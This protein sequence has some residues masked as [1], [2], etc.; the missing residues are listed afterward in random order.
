M[1]SD[2]APTPPGLYNKYRVVKV[3]G[4]TDPRAQYFVLRL[5]TDRAARLALC[6]YARVVADTNPRLAAQLLLWLIG[7]GEPLE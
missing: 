2:N 6:T 3:N 7:I 5:D 1:A 4:E